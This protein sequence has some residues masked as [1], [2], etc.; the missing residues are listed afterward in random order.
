MEEINLDLSNY[1]FVIVNPGIHINTGDSFLKLKPA[2]PERS[3]KEIIAQPIESWKI[4][5]QNDFENSKV[6]MVLDIKKIDENLT[7]RI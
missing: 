4:E 1:Q 3:I 6:A 5:L 2:I 7:K